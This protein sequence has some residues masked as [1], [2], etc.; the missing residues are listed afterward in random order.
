RYGDAK[1]EEHERPTRV[2]PQRGREAAKM[3]RSEAGADEIEGRL[4]DTEP[5]REAERRAEDPEQ[6]SLSD[7]HEDEASTGE[8]EHA[9]QR[10]LTAVSHDRERLRREAEQAACEER[11]QRKDVQVHAVRARD[12]RRAL[13]ARL[14]AFGEAPRG[15][16]ALQP[17]PERVDV[18]ARTQADIQASD[19]PEP[20]ERG[21]RRGDVHQP[22]A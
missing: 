14:G 20:I 2:E 1:S 4:G 18:D 6:N 13:D 19:A 12:A 17:P 3:P 11:V 21:L 7:H 9:Q 10:E 16:L 15:E 8:S 22:E 5:E